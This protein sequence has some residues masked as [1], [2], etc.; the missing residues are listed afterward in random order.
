MDQPDREAEPYFSQPIR[1]I[2]LMILVLG[3]VGFGA[4]IAFPS[5]APN[6]TRPSTRIIRMIWR[7]G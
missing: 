6:P 2:I 5:V 1:Q 3:L 4:Y 7:M